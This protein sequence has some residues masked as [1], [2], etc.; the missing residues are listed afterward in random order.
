MQRLLQASTR[1]SCRACQTRHEGSAVQSTVLIAGSETDAQA[2]VP[3]SASSALRL[4]PLG[5]PDLSASQTGQCSQGIAASEVSPIQLGRGDVSSVP[6]QAHPIQWCTGR[7]ALTGSS[8]FSCQHLFSP[9]GA[10]SGRQAYASAAQAVAAP[11]QQLL[12]VRQASNERPALSV[13]RHARSPRKRAAIIA[14]LVSRYVQ[15]MGL[16]QSACKLPQ[17]LLFC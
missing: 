17:H 6:C 15:L 1:A 4:S 2:S 13:Q 11:L 5:H 3:F 16:L 14:R 10:Y 9:L 7:E 12:A 8:A